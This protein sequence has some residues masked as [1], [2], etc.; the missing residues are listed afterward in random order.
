MLIKSNLTN[1][2]YWTAKK[3]IDAND[4]ATGAGN[5][6]SMFVLTVWE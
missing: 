4:N 2:I 5:D 3:K 1:R 6:R